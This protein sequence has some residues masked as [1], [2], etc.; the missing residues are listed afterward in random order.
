MTNNELKELYRIG[1]GIPELAKESGAT[2]DRIKRKLAAWKMLRPFDRG[3]GPVQKRRGRKRRLT[4]D[5]ARARRDLLNAGQHGLTTRELQ[6]LQHRQAFSCAICRHVPRGKNRLVVDTAW[7]SKQLLCQKCLEI[8]N[9]V[10]LTL[11]RWEK[12][13]ALLAT[14]L[15]TTVQEEIV[16]EK[17]EEL[18][19]TANIRDNLP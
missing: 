17:H 11:N 3:R 7:G 10:I 16:Q 18:E 2:E 19:A 15:P 12:G 8:Q 1:R 13:K 6:D 4:P 14:F 5:Q 9:V